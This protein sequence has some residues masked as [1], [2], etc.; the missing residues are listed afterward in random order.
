MVINFARKGMHLVF[1]TQSL[2]P[3]ASNKVIKFLKQVKG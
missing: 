2:S 1:S 3:N